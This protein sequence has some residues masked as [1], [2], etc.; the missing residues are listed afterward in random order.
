[1]ACC[2]VFIPSMASP[3]YRQAVLHE[4]SPARRL[5]RHSAPAAA[6]RV[7][8]EEIRRT[9]HVERPCEMRDLHLLGR[10]LQS[11]SVALGHPL[12]G[13]KFADDDRQH[14]RGRLEQS[15]EI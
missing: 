14:L 5:E 10:L 12:A 8:H 15:G 1:M 9:A 4:R 13:A 3:W 6:A 11:R 2:S 7:V